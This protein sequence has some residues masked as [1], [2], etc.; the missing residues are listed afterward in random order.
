MTGLIAAFATGM[1]LG[2]VYFAGLWLTVRRLPGT[3]HPARLVFASYVLRL[4][5]VAAIL[6][7]LGRA[8]GWP[9]LVAALGGF[10]LARHAAVRR[11]GLTPGQAEDPGP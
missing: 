3:P 4:G 11:M 8:G 1:L 7:F 10:L 9:W 6:V 2:V 5:V